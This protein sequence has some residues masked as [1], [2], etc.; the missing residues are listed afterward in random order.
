MNKKFL[1]KSIGLALVL[2]TAFSATAFAAQDEKDVNG[3]KDTPQA[4]AINYTDDNELGLKVT[5][6]LTTAATGTVLNPVSITTTAGPLDFGEAVTVG[7]NTTFTANS[8]KAIGFGANNY[9]NSGTSTLVAKDGVTSTGTLTN[10][11]GTTTINA[12][13]DVGFGATTLTDGAL[14]ITTAGN[15]TLAA[16]TVTKGNFTVTGAGTTGITLKS[17]TQAAGAT[18]LNGPTT[19]STASTVNGGTVD[20]NGY[21]T[22]TAG[23]FKVGSEQNAAPVVVTVN[24]P[25]DA[26]V[27]T[28]DQT[29]SSSFAD[30]VTVKGKAA[31]GDAAAITSTLNLNGNFK[32]S[33]AQKKITADAAGIVN[34]SGYNYVD[35]TNKITLAA[36]NGGVL[37]ITGVKDSELNADVEVG[38]NAAST[39]NVTLA[40]AWSGDLSTKANNKSVATITIND[41]GA[42]TGKATATAG[43]DI[44]NVNINK[45]GTWTNNSDTTLKEVKTTLAG[46]TFVN[47]ADTGTLDNLKGYGDVVVAKGANANASTLTISNLEDT[48]KVDFVLRSTYG[49]AQNQNKDTFN[50]TKLVKADGKDSDAKVASNSITLVSDFDK[51]EAQFAADTKADKE[52]VVATFKAPTTTNIVNKVNLDGVRFLDPTYKVAEEKATVGTFDVVMVGHKSS[53]LTEAIKHNVAAT[54]DRAVAARVLSDRASLRNDLVGKKDGNWVR[55]KHVQT[56]LKDAFSTSG[57]AYELGYNKVFGNYQNGATLELSRDNFEYKGDFAGEGKFSGTTLGAYHTQ[58]LKDKAYLDYSAK[59]GSTRSDVNLKVQGQDINHKYNT[60][61]TILAVEYGKTIPAGNWSYTPQV[62]LQYA[63]LGQADFDSYKQNDKYGK[64]HLDGMNSFIARAGVDLTY[65][66]TDKLDVVTSLNLMHEFAGKQEL[67][68]QGVSKYDVVKETVDNGGTWFGVG[69]G[70]NYKA[71]KLTSYANVEKLFGNDHGKDLQFNIGVKYGF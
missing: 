30:S 17:L 65:Q 6:A 24:G 26:K 28:P 31:A 70:V 48:S 9:T 16:T 37:N 43:S 69:L 52:A 32:A 67:T 27:K 33:A 39:A 14:S 50:I 40:G 8:A 36:D 29:P 38:E 68:A 42:W 57:N 71:D 19:L 46:G 34:I 18:V 53:E 4:T 63:H 54:Y 15:V 41:G 23:E 47:G 56:G 44:I 51:V 20:V 55:F 7:E 11:I 58:F 1:S 13:E 45:G 60:K 5:G 2:G 21:L 25:T 64:V 22:T 62:A 3:L 66:A 61:H 49:D 10:T 59:F 35:K 12:G